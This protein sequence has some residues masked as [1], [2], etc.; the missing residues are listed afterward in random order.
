[1]AWSANLW[2]WKCQDKILLINYVW[3]LVKS[4]GLP[5]RRTLEQHEHRRR[6]GN[7]INLELFRSLFVFGIRVRGRGRFCRSSSFFFHWPAEL[8]TAQKTLRYV[9]VR[10]HRS[11]VQ[12]KQ[13][14]TRQSSNDPRTRT[15]PTYVITAWQA[16][17]DLKTIN[18]S[19]KRFS[20]KV[21]QLSIIR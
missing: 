16:K 19:E 13:V 9:S 1:M 11:V 10:H 17:P 5:N 8:L 15:P 18:F 3:L 20:G 6:I 21:T 14:D 7:R 12:K 4:Q 2:F